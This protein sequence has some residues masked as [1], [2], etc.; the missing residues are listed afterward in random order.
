MTDCRWFFAVIDGFWPSVTPNFLVVKSK[1]KMKKKKGFLH[2]IVATCATSYNT[3]IVANWW[4]NFSLSPSWPL[5]CNQTPL[6]SLSLRVVPFPSSRVM[7]GHPFSLSLRV[8]HEHSG[9]AEALPHRRLRWAEPLALSHTSLV[10]LEAKNERVRSGGRVG[11]P[12]YVVDIFVLIFIFNLSEPLILSDNSILLV[13]I[14]LIF[15][16]F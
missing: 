2:C 15:Y 13:H 6:L 9:V 5:S 14:W 1:K 3:S 11:Q 8:F 12:L 16:P 7:R 4:L 10:V